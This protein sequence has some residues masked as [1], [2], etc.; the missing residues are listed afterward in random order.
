MKYR[1]QSNIKMFLK[2]MN[3]RNR[4]R[5]LYKVAK[6]LP[7][8][9]LTGHS[10]NLVT[11]SKTFKSPYDNHRILQLTLLN[12]RICWLAYVLFIQYFT[13]MSKGF[14]HLYSLSHLVGKSFFQNSVSGW[15]LLKVDL[16]H[17]FWWVTHEFQYLGNWN[18]F[19][20]QILFT[21]HWWC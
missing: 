12:K 10:Q 17:K 18:S 3:H 6:W 5:L 14:G 20:H 16:P 1:A 9:N 19:R 8:L 21:F 11:H 13:V 4:S 15:I 2:A 7:T